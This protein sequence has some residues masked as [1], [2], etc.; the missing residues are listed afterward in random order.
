M[1][2]SK[3]K[4]RN[5]YKRD[6][7]IV[8]EWNNT[9]EPDENLFGLLNA[10]EWNGHRVLKRKRG[11]AVVQWPNETFSSLEEAMDK[12]PHLLQ[13]AFYTASSYL[14]SL[15]DDCKD[16]KQANQWCFE[17][18]KKMTKNGGDVVYLDAETGCTTQVMRKLSQTKYRLVVVNKSRHCLAKILFA[19]NSP[20]MILAPCKLGDFFNL[21]MPQSIASLF[22]DY[23]CTAEGNKKDNIRPMK[24]LKTYFQRQLPKT[25]GCK[26]VLAVTFCLRNSAHTATSILET[27]Q[28]IGWEH[29]YQC[30]E[31]KVHQYGLMVFFLLTVGKISSP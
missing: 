28:T 31:Q 14:P 9:L 11:G 18:T 20:N 4:V 25:D 15:H 17:V 21:A 23:C 29:G 1:L 6:G 22:A 10:D 2:A 26:A 30:C 12:Y 16:K 3:Y 19:C 7:K 8:I 27:I 5:L 13:P 24:D